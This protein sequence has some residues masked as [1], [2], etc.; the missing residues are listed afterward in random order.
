M[1]DED[2]RIAERAFRSTGDPVD[3]EAWIQAVLRTTGLPTIQLVTQTIRTQR[4]LRSIAYSFS[5]GS[6]DHRVEAA[7]SRAMK[8]PVTP[9][10]IVSFIRGGMG[11]I[12]AG[13]SQYDPASI[14]PP[15]QGEH[16]CIEPGCDQ[17]ATE[18]GFY[19]HPVFCWAHYCSLHGIN[20]LICG[21]TPSDSVTPCMR[22]RGHHDPHQGEQDEVL[23]P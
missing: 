12:E 19:P 1:S 10:D 9:Y 18:Q 5:S 20:P 21:I 8:K 17:P 6:S 7:F 2:I 23:Q 16:L 22:P 15:L 4:A 13:H 11:W 14:A 3:G